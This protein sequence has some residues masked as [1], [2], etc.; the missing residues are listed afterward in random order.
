M[1]SGVEK[2][3]SL[4]IRIVVGGDPLIR[5]LPLRRTWNLEYLGYLGDVRHLGYLR[6][7]GYLGCLRYLGHLWIPQLVGAST[8]VP[9]SRA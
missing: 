1:T 4:R 7:L 9:L 5:Y 8:F 2:K 3:F 6:F